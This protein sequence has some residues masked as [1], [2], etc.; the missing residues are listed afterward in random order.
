MPDLHLGICVFACCNKPHVVF[1]A[2]G[3]NA[4][5]AEADFARALIAMQGVTGKALTTM[6]VTMPGE[7]FM[8]IESNYHGL[9][10]PEIET[11]EPATETLQ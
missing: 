7:Q 11:I 9:D 5:E 2:R 4:E 10:M 6:F 1:A 8:E 3:N